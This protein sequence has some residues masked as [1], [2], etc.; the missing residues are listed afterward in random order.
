VFERPK[1]LRPAPPPDRRRRL[2]RWV[3]S[4]RSPLGR[5]LQVVGAADQRLLLTLRTRGHSEG[6]DRVVGALGSFGEMGAGWIGIGVA[7]A[8]L[9]P[10]RRDRWLAASCVAPVTML[11]NYAVKLTIGR[12]RPLID[13]HPPLAGAPSKL[14]FPSA[15]STSGVAAAVALGRVAP[16]ARPALLGLAAAICLG[17]PY[18]GMHYPSDV[19]AGAA[20]G[21]VIGRSFPLPAD[22]EPAAP[23]SEIPA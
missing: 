4:R 5:A 13:D 8:A 17:R 3:A 22:D 12:E 9:D 10:S 20:L 19:L 1:S 21:A 6:L 14:S 15:H 7:G 16:A 2:A 23:T 11:V 18:L